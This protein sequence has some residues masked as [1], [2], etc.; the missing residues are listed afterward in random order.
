MGGSMKLSEHVELYH[1]GNVKKYAKSVNIP[2]TTAINQ[3]ANGFCVDGTRVFKVFYDLPQTEID[4]IK[5]VR[6]I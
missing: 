6:G 1:G 5:K 3:I 2:Y 4:H